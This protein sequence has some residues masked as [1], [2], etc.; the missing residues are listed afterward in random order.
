MAKIYQDWSNR[1]HVTALTGS[2]LLLTTS[3]NDS[4]AGIERSE[5][6]ALSTYFAQS[7]ALIGPLIG[8]T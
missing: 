3:S 6:L 5:P 1:K 2:G 8:E 7:E 4:P